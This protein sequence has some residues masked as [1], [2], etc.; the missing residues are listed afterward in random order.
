M[1]PAILP[2]ASKI[3]STL[4][5]NNSLVPLAIKDVANS[6][7]LTTGSYIV[8][9]QTEGKDR[10]IDEF[11][12]QAI[13][14]FG[15]PAYKKLLDLT[16][17]K[18]LGFDSE[19][20]VR[21]LKNKDIF[22]KAKQYA[23]SDKIKASLEKAGSKQKLF[24]GLTLAKFG[25]S[26]LMTIFTYWGLTKYR[27]KTT[28][29][30][31]KK[32]LRAKAAAK[33][34]KNAD[35]TF[36]PQTA[37][38][39][40][41]AF[42]DVHKKSQKNNS[43]LNFTGRIEDFMFSPVKNLMIVDGAITTERLAESRNK[44]DFIG[45]AIKEG[46]FWAFMYFAGQKIQE[47]FEKKSEQKYNRSIDLDARVIESEELKKAFKDKTLKNSLKAFE[48]AKT[49]A[50]IYEFIMKNPDN[51]VVQMAKKSDIITTFKKGELKGKVDTR[52]YIDIN[53]V[54]GIKEKLE[55]LHNQYTNSKLHNSKTENEA[56]ETFLAQ[57][58][59]LKRISVI[60][61]IGACIGALGV[62]APA[63]MVAMRYIGKDN[64]DFQVKKDIEKKLA[65]ES[66]E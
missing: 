8:G 10:F 47:H 11:G 22:E 64:K 51:F 63:L 15:I 57:V 62:A 44:Q 53:E 48:N 2:S 12:T 5:N 54:K 43:A 4:G 61:N 30:N 52:K 28:E 42:S 35:T 32:E 49:D 36:T 58:K 7:G 16:I 65:F 17:F 29:E 56:L 59:K 19:I 40:I 60:K 55:K 9:D 23:P 34:Q 33:K 38:Q 46:S 27:H 1:L 20:D 6:I 66:A 3:Y 21:N 45:Y 50:E 25:V 41:K 31:I 14:L 24:K 37:P 39:N 13:W 26:T 18:P